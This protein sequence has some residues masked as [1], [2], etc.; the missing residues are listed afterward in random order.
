MMLQIVKI[1]TSP[2]ALRVIKEN[3]KNDMNYRFPLDSNK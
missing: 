2:S 3:D 1:W